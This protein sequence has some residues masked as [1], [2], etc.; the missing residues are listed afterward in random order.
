MIVAGETM[1]SVCVDVDMKLDW[2]KFRYLDSPSSRG[3]VKS[4]CVVEEA[5]LTHSLQAREV[6]CANLIKVKE[7]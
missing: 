5:E 3:P 1:K 6:L 4:I 7:L 2:I